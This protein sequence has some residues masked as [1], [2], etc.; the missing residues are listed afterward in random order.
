MCIVLQIDAFSSLLVMDREPKTAVGVT[1]ITVFPDVKEHVVVPCL[2]LLDPVPDRAS[3]SYCNTNNNNKYLCK[4]SSSSSE[5]L[6]HEILQKKMA[7][8]MK[9]SRYKQFTKMRHFIAV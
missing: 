1:G 2:I 4:V 5:T 7:E 3:G 8:I 9:V 6:A